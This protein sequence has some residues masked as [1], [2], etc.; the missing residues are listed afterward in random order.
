MA[1]FNAVQANTYFNTKGIAPSLWSD[2]TDARKNIFLEMASDRFDALPWKSAYDT[3]TKRTAFAAISAAFYEY[4]RYLVERDGLPDQAVG[5][6]EDPDELNALSDLPRNVSSRL[7]PFLDFSEVVA[8]AT[9]SSVTVEG[10]T[11]QYNPS[12]ETLSEATERFA[13]AAQHRA[14]AARLG[15][16]ESGDDDDDEDTPI[17]LRTITIDGISVQYDPS[18]ETPSQAFERLSQAALDRARTG[19]EFTEQEQATQ[20][21]MRPMSFMGASRGADGGG[22]TPAPVAVKA[23]AALGGR[24]IALADTDFADNVEDALDFNRVT[25][26]PT[27]RVLKVVSIDGRENDFTISAGAATSG[28]NQGEVDGRVKSAANAASETARGNIELATR[29]EAIAGTDQERAVTPA[30]LA[31]VFNQLI[32]PA[33]RL[34]PYSR[35]NAGQVPTVDAAG[36]AIEYRTPAAGGGG[37]TTQEQVQDWMNSALTGG[38]LQGIRIEYDD[39]NNEF[40]ISVEI[41]QWRSGTQYRS[42]NIVRGFS[43]SYVSN[44]YFCLR[45]HTATGNNEPIRRSSPHWV[46][47]TNTEDAG[48]IFDAIAPGLTG[49]S[50]TGID[51][52]FDNA[53]NEIDF[54]VN[55]T[56]ALIEAVGYQKT[57]ER[58]EAFAAFG[59]DVWKPAD[60]GAT[61]PNWPFVSTTLSTVERPTN[62][63]DSFSYAASHVLPPNYT[64]DWVIVKVP[65]AQASMLS[66]MRLSIGNV[67]TDYRSDT[68]PMNDAAK[69]TYLEQASGFRYYSVKV[70]NKPSGDGWFVERFTPFELLPGKIAPLDASLLANAPQTPPHGRQFTLLSPLVDTT[71]SRSNKFTSLIALSP[72]LDLDDNPRGEFHIEA[73]VTTSILSGTDVNYGFEQGKANQTSDDRRRTVSQILFASDLLSAA[74]PSGTSR[75]ASGALSIARVPVYSAN[76]TLGYWRLWLGRDANKVVGLFAGYETAGGNAL[77]YRF[78]SQVRISF[79]PSDAPDAVG[80][81]TA[82][83]AN[84]VGVDW[85][86][87]GALQQ[88]GTAGQILNNTAWTV[89]ADA[90]AGSANVTLDLDPGP[91]VD[92]RNLVVLPADPP[93]DTILGLWFIAE[94]AASQA[95]WTAGNFVEQGRVFRPWGSGIVTTNAGVNSYA[96]GILLTKKSTAG[97]SAIVRV[98]TNEHNG[99]LTLWVIRDSTNVGSPAVLTPNTYDAFTRVRVAPA[100]GTGAQGRRG[101]PGLQGLQG[102]QGPKGDKGDKGDTGATGPRGP[103]GTGGAGTG[104]RGVHYVDV[105]AGGNIVVNAERLGTDQGLSLAGT[106]SAPFNVNVEG[107]DSLFLVANLSSQPCTIQRTAAGSNV[108][109]GLTKTLGAG[110]YAWFGATT[111]IDLFGYMAASE[112]GLRGPAGPQGL[113]GPAGPQGVQGIQGPQGPPGAAADSAAGVRTVTLQASD[114][115]AWN[116]IGRDYRYWIP[117]AIPPGTMYYFKGSFPHRPGAGPGVVRNPR[118]DVILGN[119]GPTHFWI[120]ADPAS[121]REIV[122]LR[123]RNSEFGVDLS[124]AIQLFQASGTTHNAALMVVDGNNVHTYGGLTHSP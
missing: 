100:I 12:E 109:L 8:A 25:W 107:A 82:G 33:N 115:T 89:S 71:S 117:G 86:T 72:S 14:Q 47:L 23:Y 97:K 96:D 80:G 61:N 91:G 49:G 93:D 123:R 68:I 76:T 53:N 6:N 90:P 104:G 69:V 60:S 28:L 120:G 18:Q 59:G 11:I 13:E 7:I 26:N 94:R 65:E 52:S 101:P 45:S 36:A 5:E 98:E 48:A 77:N 87:S 112:A 35:A 74:Q 114:L 17:G 78:A 29:Q 46:E 113:Q 55:L 1:Y 64:D 19:V 22:A 57:D 67:A 38:A 84:T 103:A 105:S 63:A 92:N 3:Q 119:A 31:A 111:N 42:G 102:A 99:Q 51:V 66:A 15:A 106:P 20:R 41:D 37:G 50:N 85:F 121:D 95:D 81:G 44:V 43:P 34:P 70:A 10:N 9:T 27:T 122:Y 40:D 21:P 79:T 58:T 88:T 32:P 24:L 30:Q 39:A 62:P 4:V 16:P 110:Q 75:I 124:T 2:L 56:P 54:R 108:A 73:T 116:E 83:D 118:I